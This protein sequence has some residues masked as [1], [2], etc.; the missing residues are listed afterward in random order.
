MEYELYDL[1]AVREAEL[2]GDVHDSTTLLHPAEGKAPTK[3]EDIASISS[4]A[5]N[6][7]MSSRQNIAHNSEDDLS[8]HLMSF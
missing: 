1:D 8:V 7:S 4:E 2:E 6:A 5:Y 3:N